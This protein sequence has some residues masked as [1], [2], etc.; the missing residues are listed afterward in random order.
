MKFQFKTNINCS[1]CVEKVKP[2]LE[3]N[4]AIKKWEVDTAHKDKILKIETDRHLPIEKIMQVVEKAGFQIKP[5]STGMLGK[6]FR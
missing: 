4:K 1:G 6:L 2:F 3:G 5:R